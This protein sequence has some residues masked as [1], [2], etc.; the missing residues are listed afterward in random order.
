MS[1]VKGSVSPNFG[2]SLTAAM[3]EAGRTPYAVAKAIGSD[4]SYL[5]RVAA[6]TQVPT[7]TIAWRI[8][9]SLGM[10]LDEVFCRP[11]KPPEKSRNNS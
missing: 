3:R 2:E 5:A 7:L 6:G 10:S 1:D 4:R 9:E 8:A 11:P